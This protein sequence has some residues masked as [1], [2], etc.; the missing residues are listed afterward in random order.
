MNVL[1]IWQ[2]KK[3][4]WHFEIFGEAVEK[5]TYPDEISTSISGKI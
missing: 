5:T 4:Y 1:A 2:K 3:K